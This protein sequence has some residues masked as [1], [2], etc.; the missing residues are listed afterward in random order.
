M[1]KKKNEG[2]EEGSIKGF[3]VSVH[4]YL[5][6]I[7]ILVRRILVLI[8]G[9]LP[10]MYFSYSPIYKVRNPILILW[11]TFVESIISGKV[12]IMFVCNHGTIFLVGRISSFFIGYLDY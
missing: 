11:T 8:H 10:L 5:L 1:K 12:S 3:N 6:K 2:K 9:Y 7:S 4:F